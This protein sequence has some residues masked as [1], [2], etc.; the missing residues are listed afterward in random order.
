MLSSFAQPTSPIT[1]LD[2]LLYT[3][4]FL[5]M[6]EAVLK[7]SSVGYRHGNR[8]LSGIIPMFSIILLSFRVFY[9][10]T[11]TKNRV[12]LL[13]QHPQ[14][15]LNL[16]SALFVEITT[17]L[18]LDH[19]THQKCWPFRWTLALLLAY[20]VLFYFLDNGGSSSGLMQ[21]VTVQDNFILSYTVGITV[22]LIFKIRL[23]IYEICNLLGI[24]CFD[25]VTPYHRVISNNEDTTLTFE[26]GDN[27]N[28]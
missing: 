27:K 3:T 20:A 14:L 24:W 25:I 22:F 1:N 21:D 23:I 19:M 16:C 5:G 9:M 12:L 7:I 13:T 18:M 26:N 11:D 8:S 17:V 2:L 6:Q 4:I 15:C 28:N 10:G